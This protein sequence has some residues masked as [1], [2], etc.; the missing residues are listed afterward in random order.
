M[1]F[2]A[3]EQH[4]GI[5]DA[6]RG[7][8]AYICQFIYTIMAWTWNLLMEVSE[9]RLLN[10]GGCSIESLTRKADCLSTG[11]V[12]T[13]TPI[14]LIYKRFT[15]LLGIIMTF[16]IIFQF[17][18]Y[19]M[20]P[21]EIEDKEKGIEKLGFRLLTVAILLA[22]APMLFDMAYD[23][24][25][26]VLNS[27][28]LPKL[29]LG[30]SSTNRKDDMKNFGRAFSSDL[31]S[32]FYY[33]EGFPTSDY[34]DENGNIKLM[35]K[36]CESGKDCVYTVV[37]VRES[38][39]QTGQLS[40]LH[41]DLNSHDDF[42]GVKDGYF[43]HF[44]GLFAL[45]VGIF[46][47]YMLIMYTIDVGARVV[48]LTFLQIIAPMPIISYLSPKKDGMFQ[49]W[50]KQCGVTYADLFIRLLILFF[51]TLLIN[52][53][54][55]AYQGDE[56]AMLP[57]VD[58]SLR[59]YIYLILIIGLMAFCKRAPKMV[60]ELFPSM[61]VASG[62]FGLKPGDRP[63]VSNAIGMIGG[64][65]TGLRTL[66]MSAASQVRR[67]KDN[68]EFRKQ[69]KQDL[70]DKKQAVKDN[71]KEL[72]ELRNK[73][74]KGE[75]S[76]EQYRSQAAALREKQKLARDNRKNAA[77]ARSNT[78]YR[79]AALAGLGGF[80]G[81]TLRGAAKGA[82]LK[83]MKGFK[84]FRGKMQEVE[85]AETQRNT[86]VDTWYSEGGRGGVL[87]TIQREKASVDSKL[88]L[89]TQAKRL[90]RESKTYENKAKAL[91]NVSKREEAVWKNVDQGKDII[92]K[93]TLEGKNEIKLSGTDKERTIDKT[94]F[95]VKE[96]ETLSDAAS[97]AQ[98]ETEEAKS[99]VDALINNKAEMNR[100][101][102]KR[103][104]EITNSTD[105]E[106]TKTSKLKELEQ[107]KNEF[108]KDY[109][110]KISEAQTIHSNKQV[111]ETNVLKGISNLTI[112]TIFGEISAGKNPRESKN[113]YDAGAIQ[114]AEEALINIEV[115]NKDPETVADMEKLFEVKDP[116]TG[117]VTVEGK[118]SPYFQAFMNPRNEKVGIKN[119]ETYKKIED[120][121][122]QAGGERIK[123]ITD[124][125]EESRR[126]SESERLQ[127]AKANDSFNSSTGGGKK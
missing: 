109:D 100:E 8:C 9:I 103:K 35:G 99:T 123:K 78:R 118:N 46:I 38:F 86:A 11:G 92:R 74:K 32:N 27:E 1:Q 39:K 4:S 81:G 58:P 53:I 97:R 106:A 29:I 96:G 30:T 90:E 40:G 52:A 63:L 111:Q 10:D 115:A 70:A 57:N 19:L 66:A 122:K 51:V 77:I 36:D 85:K 54:S 28:I 24:Q 65:A 16:Y 94:S 5:W 7:L 37:A 50:L 71:K 34:W 93:K 64:A 33:V 42:G 13:D 104:I 127:A 59:L 83:E 119:W 49:K 68:R 112:G 67:N 12:W 17:I 113:N 76:D 120:M 108:N 44:D 95:V 61:G 21:D 89:P 105:D 14:T 47:T 43:I 41:Y 126:I 124:L 18:K 79:S 3:I 116:S 101:F 72:S 69:A 20:T 121:L 114:A 82:T 2:L 88:G 25:K 110:E 6:L 55:I 117:K 62:T 75:L 45:I 102:D 73:H 23:F 107:T 31:L 125:R 60:Q 22:I 26:I 15:L 48:Q 84:D 87:G 56:T 80:V 98:R 91:E